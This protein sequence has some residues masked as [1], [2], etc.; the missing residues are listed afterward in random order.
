MFYAGCH[1]SNGIITL[2][3]FQVISCGSGIG[4]GRLMVEGFGGHSYIMDVN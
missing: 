2:S 1:Y 3:K 4:F